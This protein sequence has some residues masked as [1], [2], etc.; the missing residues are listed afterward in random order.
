MSK[1]TPAVTSADSPLRQARVRLGLTTRQVGRAVGTTS[2]TVT[3]TELGQHAPKPALAKRLAALYG[4]SLD[5][6]YGA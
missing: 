4:L 1:P 3:R 6:I 5:Q 2:G